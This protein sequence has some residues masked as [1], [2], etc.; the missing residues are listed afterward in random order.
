MIPTAGPRTR[1]QYHRT[2]AGVSPLDVYLAGALVVAVEVQTWLGR[3]TTDAHWA[4]T[5]VAALVFAATVAVRGTRPGVALL[6]AVSV[7]AVQAALGGALVGNEIE[8]KQS[9]ATR[10]RITVRL[11]SGSS[12]TVEDTRDLNLRVGDRV[13]LE[14]GHISRI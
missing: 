13:R 7:V 3:Q 1:R 9:Q 4:I 6:V 12:L 8:K 11:D 14:D 10:Y 5:A 2:F